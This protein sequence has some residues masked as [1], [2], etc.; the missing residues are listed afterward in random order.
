[1][2]SPKGFYHKVEAKL[3]PAW[4]LMVMLAIVVIGITLILLWRR[5][6]VAMAAWLTYLY[7]P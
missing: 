3:E 5:N 1:M 4:P 7:M 6:A 2:I